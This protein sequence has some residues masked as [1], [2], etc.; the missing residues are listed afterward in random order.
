MNRYSLQG[1]QATACGLVN[2]IYLSHYHRWTSN[3]LNGTHYLACHHLG[4]L[5]RST[6]YRCSREDPP[7]FD[8]TVLKQLEDHQELAA[9]GQ[10]EVHRRGPGL[11]DAQLD[12]KGE[13]S[14]ANCV[15]HLKGIHL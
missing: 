9:Q 7:S 5:W 12:S 2:G 3:D 13:G 6:N 10:R 14:L 8:G 1:S 15:G 4:Y 11:L